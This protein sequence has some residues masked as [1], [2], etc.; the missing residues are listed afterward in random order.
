MHNYKFTQNWFDNDIPNIISVLKNFIGQPINLLEI[1]SFEGRS[2]VWFLNNIL[3][4]RDATITCIDCFSGSPEHQKDKIDVSNIEATY[5]YNINQ[6]GVSFKVKKLIGKSQEI[7]R[8]LSLDNY[9]VVYIDGSHKACDVLE[10]AVL[11]FRLLKSNGIMMFDDYEWPQ[12]LPE[13]EKPK[14]GIDVFLNVFSGQYELLHH[15]GQV[16]IRKL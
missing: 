13:T 1:G 6:S 11:C 16:Y 2:T 8:L 4:H 3:T 9:H 10:D 5:E 12:N 14:L 15:Q 7:L